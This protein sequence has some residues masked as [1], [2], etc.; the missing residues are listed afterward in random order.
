MAAR[1]IHFGPDD[2]H[3]LMVLRSAG[4]A[5]DGCESLA[6]LRRLLMAEGV[7]EAVLLSDGP[8]VELKEAAT[9]TRSCSSAPVVLF[10]GTNRAY[11]GMSFDL[12]VH[13]LT[14]P[15]A[16]LHEVDKVIGES[17]LLGKPLSALSRKSAQRLEES[18]L[19]VNKS[20]SERMRWRQGRAQTVVPAPAPDDRLGPDS[21]FK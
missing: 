9:L 19:A 2:C 5:V 3:R 4:Y 16:W 15:E 12:V 11:E 21:A 1:I 7:P 10:S 20:R 8:G 6:Q 18:A 13:S 14:P 17:R